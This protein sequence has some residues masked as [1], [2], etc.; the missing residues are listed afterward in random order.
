[1]NDAR[2]EDSVFSDQPIKLRAAG[3]DDLTVISA[4]VQD[5][6]C[7]TADL[8]WMPN[9][10]RLVVILHRFRW[11]DRSAADRHKRPYERVQSALTINLA[12]GIRARGIEQAKRE[13]VLS[14]LSCGLVEDDTD[15]ARVELIFAED[16]TLSLNVDYL[17]VTLSDLTRPW[18][19]KGD[20]A[21]EHPE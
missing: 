16:A 2:F 11:E 10:R 12:S 9:T 1:M 18:A 15:G 13:Q 19:A 3:Q 5:A 14:L 6:V 21:P 4:L 7:K 8:H 17:D 20:Q